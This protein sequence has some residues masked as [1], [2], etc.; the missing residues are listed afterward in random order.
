MSGKQKLQSNGGKRKPIGQF[1]H[2]GCDSTLD[3]AVGD[4]GTDQVQIQPCHLNVPRFEF[5]SAGTATARDALSTSTAAVWWSP[6]ETLDPTCFTQRPAIIPFDPVP[7]A[8]DCNGS[9]RRIRQPEAQENLT[10]SK[11]PPESSVLVVIDR[12]CRAD[13]VEQCDSCRHRKVRCDGRQPCTTCSSTGEECAYG[14]EA[15]PKSKSDLILDVAL[16]S[17]NILHEMSAKLQTLLGAGSPVDPRVALSPLEFVSPT[18]IESTH[19]PGSPPD[20]ISN[21]ILSQFHSST[22]ES[23]LAWPHFK[24]YHALRQNYRGSVFHLE[25]LRPPFKYRASSVLPYV[26][27]SEVD[28]ILRSFERNVNFWYP[29]LSRDVSTEVEVQVL[30]NNLDDGISS[31]VSL[32]VMALGCAS[33]LIQS[34]ATDSPENPAE[35]EQRHRWQL[36]GRLHFDLA[37]KKVHLAQAECTTEAVQC[38]FFTAVFFAFLQRPIQ[39]W[40]FISAAAI[41]CRLLLSYTASESAPEQLECLRRIFWSCYILESDYLAELSALPQTGIAGIESSIPLPGEYHTHTSAIEEEQSSL[42][43]LACISMRRLLNRVH[44]LLYARNGGV[45]SDIHQF[46]TVVAELDHQLE[47]WKDLLPPP[48][49]FAL[50]R[51]PA[52][53]PEGGFLRQRYLACK[54][55]IYRPYLTWALSS[56]TTNAE[57][58]TPMVY[59]GCKTCMEACCLHAQNLQSFPQTV[60]VD[61]WIC[62]LSM[63][64]VMLIALAT[65]RESALRRCLLPD[66]VDIGPNLSKNLTR[67][68]QIPGQGVS[69]SVLQSVRLIDDASVSL[70]AMLDR[71]LAIP[72]DLVY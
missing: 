24:D 18:T 55:V 69:P 21:A 50:S 19:R 53:S 70:R 10:C 59:E 16:R 25:S 35:L 45:G 32:L 26:S 63:A 4:V 23:I 57:P 34:V 2:G 7:S 15:I 66:A 11:Y 3:Y 56:T 14:A 33:E 9:R 44:D 29:T 68:M 28:S 31:C 1:P 30:S 46:P 51:E 43:F 27:K 40:S 61:T 6:F 42:Y 5:A 64:S 62:S 52:P 49:Q 47:R 60:M 65:S 8:E 12:A 36:M 22:T 38:L 67:W 72:S 39:A 37:F 41:K 20:Q 13:S 54:S 17:E 58:V 71:W 48:F